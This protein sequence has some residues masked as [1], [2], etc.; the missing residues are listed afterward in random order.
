[1]LSN[2]GLVGYFTLFLLI[3]VVLYPLYKNVFV[4]KLS[5]NP[6]PLYRNIFKLLKKIHPVFAS[7]AI[8]TGLYHGFLMLGGFRIH[9]GSLI[10]IAL[11]F[12]GATYLAGKTKSLR[13][14]WRIYHR[15]G[16]LVTVT[17]VMIHLF[18]PYLI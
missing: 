15:A 8:I 10:I 4:K 1:M 14:K 13:T 9:T 11:L 7:T 2:A 6:K 3:T 5:K 16:G 18:F 12:M 17:A